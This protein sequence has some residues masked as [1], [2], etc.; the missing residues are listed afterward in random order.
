MRK[1]FTDLY[2]RPP[3]AIAELQTLSAPTDSRNLRVLMWVTP[4]PLVTASHLHFQV[5]QKLYFTRKCYFNKT[6]IPYQSYSAREYRR[7]LKGNSVSHTDQFDVSHDPIE[8][9]KIYSVS[10]TLRQFSISHLKTIQYHTLISLMCHM[11]LLSH[12]KYIQYLTLKGNSVS[13][14]DQFDVSHD[15]IESLKGNSSI[16]H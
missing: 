10:H 3:E 16:S 8:P 15:P 11:T 6:E 4:I 1:S 14:T 2:R 13:H 12:L 7:P 5:Y 9:L